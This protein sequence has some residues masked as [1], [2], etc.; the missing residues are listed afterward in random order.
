MPIGAPTAPI[1]KTGKTTGSKVTA[2][3]LG[4]TSEREEGLKG[5]GQ[6]GTMVLIMTKNFADAGAV[7]MHFPAIAHEVA[8]L[9]QE[10][11]KVA[12]I[13]DRI[14]AVGP[15]AGLLTAV[16][17][18]ALQLLVNHDRIQS[19]AAGMLGGKVMSKEALEAKVK[20][21]IDQATTRM[22]KEAQDARQEAEQAAKALKDAA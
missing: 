12:T 6:I 3:S 7:D 8:E 16:M 21:E 18:L 5:I 11:E 10:N 19:S 1:A 9:A 20:A 13:V 22:L 17:P 14:I 4:K 2:A 15:Y